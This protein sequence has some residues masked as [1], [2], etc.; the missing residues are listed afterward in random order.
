MTLKALLQSV[1]GGAEKVDARITVSL[2]GGQTQTIKV[3]PDQ[4][5]VV[6][7]L[8]FDDLNPGQDNRV[9]IQVDGSGNLMY[10]IAGS[11]YIP[12]GKLSQYPELSVNEQLVDIKVSY[13]RTSL[14]VNDT[15]NVSVTVSMIQEGGVAKS[16]LIDL[17]MP[18][19]FT[20]QAEDLDALVARFNDLPGDYVFPK[21]E[22]YELTGRQILVYVSNLSYSK[23]LLFNYRLRAKY[24]LMAQTPPSNAYDYYNPGISGEVEPEL[25]VVNP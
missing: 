5:D 6:Q 22:R 4:Y 15:V 10:Q 21:I 13:D 7:L 8:S 14:S 3:T 19:G 16:A 1:R 12:W 24:P 11:Y 2:N 25:L 17:G 9:D 20:V 18:P 23:P